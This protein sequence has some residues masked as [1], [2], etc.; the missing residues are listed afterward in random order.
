MK[1]I[2]SS[3]PC[4]LV[5]V[6]ADLLDQVVAHLSGSSAECF[7]SPAHHKGQ[8]GNE[9]IHPVDSLQLRPRQASPKVILWTGGVI[10]HKSLRSEM[11]QHTV[12]V[13]GSDSDPGEGVL[14]HGYRCI[15]VTQCYT[16][17]AR[18]RGSNT[19]EATALI[20]IPSLTFNLHL[21][22]GDNKVG[23]WEKTGQ[24]VK[25]PGHQRDNPPR[26]VHSPAFL[27][28][29]QMWQSSLVNNQVTLRAL[30]C[31]GVTRGEGGLSSDL[32][33]FG[34]PLSLW[35]ATQ[36]QKERKSLDLRLERVPSPHTS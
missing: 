10:R 21:T 6:L 27:L 4:L 2:Y 18:T 8:W 12:A 22:G 25:S 30:V 9:H 17:D 16:C 19:H 5:L 7:F 34:A 36:Q 32:Q 1:H 31:V 35:N 26:V 28:L 29:S 13:R 20:F 3:C 23:K 15:T 24:E 11:D 33:S 14:A